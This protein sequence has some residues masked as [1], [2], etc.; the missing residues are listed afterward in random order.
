MKPYQRRQAAAYPYYKLATWDPRSLTFRDGKV[1]FP[2][3]VHAIE[4]IDTEGKYRISEVTDAGRKDL[5]VI[6]A[7]RDEN[8]MPFLK[9]ESGKYY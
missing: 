4:S 3:Q 7:Y 1:A 9:G 2:T 8:G 6:T 5:E